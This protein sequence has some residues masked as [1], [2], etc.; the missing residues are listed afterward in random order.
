M[1][2][3]GGLVTVEWDQKA[4]AAYIKR[5]DKNHGRPLLQRA[6]KVT[7][8]AARLLVAPLRA[9]IPVGPPRQMAGA[10]VRGG[11]SRRR[12]GVKLLRKQGRED[13]RPTWVGS[14]AWY[15]RFPTG[16][17]RAHSLASRSGKSQF[18]VFSHSV[19]RSSRAILGKAYLSDVR[20]LIGITVSGITPRPWVSDAVASHQDAVMRRIAK[21]VWD[22]R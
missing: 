4:I 14:K 3:K 7:N 19:S 10:V 13:I 18:A 20:P 5:L 8:A 16:G 2:P 15:F 1:P 22:T 6:E 12:V 9:N 21:D 17:T 11:N